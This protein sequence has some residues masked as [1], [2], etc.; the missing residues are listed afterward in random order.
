M[1]FDTVTDIINRVNDALVDD[2]FTRW[3]KND[4][5]SY[6]NEAQK[7]I[8]LIRPDSFVI[9]VE[10]TCT[11]GTKQAL[12]DEAL[13]L[14]DVRYNSVSKRAIVKKERSEITEYDPGWYGTTGETDAEA[15]V[16]DERDPKVFFVYP[17]LAAGSKLDIVCSKTPA[18]I[19]VADIDTASSSLQSVYTNAIVEFMLY[20]AHSKDFEYSEQ[21]KAVTHYQMFRTILNAK[22][23][24]E[25]GM[26]PTNKE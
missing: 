25:I 4:L 8:V 22:S 9:D 5:L 1:A 13:R 23:E 14:V 15:F 19:P 18:E 3:P 24:G 10:L 26:T 7:A 20:K 16:Y 12:P 6:L 11:D 2:Q 17:G 21:Q